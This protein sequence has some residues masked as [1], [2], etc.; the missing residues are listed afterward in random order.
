MAK[1]DSPGGV[2]WLAQISS[3]LLSDG[4]FWFGMVNVCQSTL[5]PCNLEGSNL[6]ARH[7]KCSREYHTIVVGEGSVSS[8]ADSS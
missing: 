4:W 2:D 5:E 8:N 7:K 6:A 1:M 3:V